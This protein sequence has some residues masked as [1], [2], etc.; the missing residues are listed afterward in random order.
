MTFLSNC[1][2]YKEGY[3]YFKIEDETE[4]Y[5]AFSY[6]YDSTTETTTLISE[7]GN[8]R[9]KFSGDMERSY[10]TEEV[11]VFIDDENF[12]KDGYFIKCENAAIGCGFT[13]F[14]VTH[15][16]DNEGLLRVSF[17]G[18]LW[19]QTIQNPTAGNYMIEGVIVI[20]T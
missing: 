8:I 4:V 5:Q 20:K 2:E 11:N 14:N 16:E 17:E 12:G 15:F 19:M 3:A 1:Q 6:E 18:K 10:N 9:M 7:E 13:M